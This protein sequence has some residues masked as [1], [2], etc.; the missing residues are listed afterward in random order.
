MGQIN[1]HSVS[2]LSIR[3]VEI[4]EGAKAPVKVSVYMNELA[5]VFQVDEVLMPK[6]KTTPLKELVEISVIA[7]EKELK[8]YYPH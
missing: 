1:I 6:L 2:A 5:G 8:T 4:A 7:G 3:M